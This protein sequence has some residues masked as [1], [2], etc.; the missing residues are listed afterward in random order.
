M[1]TTGFMEKVGKN[2][3][4]M[5]WVA[6]DKTDEAQQTFYKSLVK[7]GDNDKAFDDAVRAFQR[8]TNPSKDMIVLAKQIGDITKDT[9]KPNKQNSNEWLNMFTQHTAPMLQLFN[10]WV[11][12]MNGVKEIR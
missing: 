4:I 5:N 9:V 11:D 1:N 2:Y 7:N 8:N 10:S 3:Q 6:M 12:N